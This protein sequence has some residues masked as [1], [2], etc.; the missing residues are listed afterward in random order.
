MGWKE[1]CA[2]S[3]RMKFVLDVTRGER[4]LAEACRLAGISRRTGYKWLNRL[5]EAQL[6]GLRDRSHRPDTFPHATTTAVTAD[7]QWAIQLRL[8]LED[9][10]K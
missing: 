8:G 5:H 4:S 7:H 2:V 3:E 10:T 9:A 6:D 1:T